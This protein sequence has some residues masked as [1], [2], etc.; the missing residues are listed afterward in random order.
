MNVT[1]YGVRGSTPCPADANRRYGGNTS[2]VALES[3][4]HDPIVLDLGTGL[5]TY[6]ETLAHDGSFHG[7]ALVTHVHWDH[8]QGLPFFLPVLQPGASFEVYGP[9]LPDRSLAECFETFVSPPFFPVSIGQLPGAITFSDVRDT[10]LSVGDAKVKVR[11]V[12]HTS[13]TNGYR[14]EQDGVSVA[15][16]SDHQMPVDDPNAI[17]DDVLELCEGVDLL[18]HDAQY[19][20]MEFAAKS[21]WG[22]CTVDYAVHVAIEAGVSRLALFHHD[23]SHGDEF[24]DCLLAGAR[25]RAGGRLDEV[26]AAAEGLTVVL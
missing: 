18:I 11:P 25:E 5:R 20:P 3:A 15:Y 8:V 17:S 14:V 26:L 4:G 22:H 19:T 16:V 12:P 7:H 6:G 1:F 2:C 10:D 23:P 13:A 24:V 21:T 9:P